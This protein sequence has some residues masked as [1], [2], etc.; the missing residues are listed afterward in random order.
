MIIVLFSIVA[1]VA[2]NM[3]MRGIGATLILQLIAHS[4][5]EFLRAVFRSLQESQQE[6][7]IKLLH[8][9][10]NLLLIPLLLSTHSIVLTL[11]V[12]GVLTAL[13]VVYTRYRISRTLP[14]ESTSITNSYTPQALIRAGWMFALSGLFVNI[15]YYADSLFIQWFRPYDLVGY[16]NAAYKIIT[17]C[18]MP[19]AILGSALV[20]T[21]HHTL[22]HTPH[23]FLRLVIWFTAVTGLIYTIICLIGVW[24]A[25]DI[26]HLLYGPSYL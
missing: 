2:E 8:G 21:L 4:A 13:I 16:Y 22:H 26:I 3:L 20:P 6:T 9:L 11:L 12:Q 5:L 19:M 7:A 14:Q 24:V 17:V 25:P 18:I 10:G 23:R 1:I 15:Y